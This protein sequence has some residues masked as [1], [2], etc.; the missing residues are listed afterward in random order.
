MHAGGKLVGWGAF[1]VLF[2]FGRRAFGV[3]A[4]RLGE[5]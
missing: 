3:V 4:G 2:F 5:G 1:E